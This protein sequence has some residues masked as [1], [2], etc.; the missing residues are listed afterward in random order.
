MCTLALSLPS[1]VS[2]FR[3]A[4]LDIRIR[5]AAKLLEM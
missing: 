5:P 4:R 3:V 1:L 2:V